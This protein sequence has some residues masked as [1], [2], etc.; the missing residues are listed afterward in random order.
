MIRKIISF[1]FVL[2]FFLSENLF[3]EA[4]FIPISSGISFGVR[5]SWMKWQNPK[6]YSG[7]LVGPSATL[8]YRK[9]HFIYGGARFF[10]TY[11]DLDHDSC[12]GK[13]AQILNLEARFGYSF[14]STFIFTPY[15]GGGIIISNLR[16][17]NTDGLCHR[18]VF[19]N[20][21]IPVG[22]LITYHFSDVFSIGIDY[23]YMPAVDSFVRESGFKNVRWS[24]NERG[25][26]NVEIP[27]QFVFPNPRFKDVQYRLTPFFRTYRY[28]SNQ[29][30]CHTCDNGSAAIAEQKAYEIGL[31]YDVVLF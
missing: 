12:I 10:L 9:P 3:S 26:H 11:G 13:R 16:L 24:L 8:D 5:G 29:V 2:F 22:A 19:T 28:G 30:T 31:K 27:I 15:T 18:E 1:F 23:T 7:Y 25:S 4:D 6:D 20:I 17:K 14:G 21:Y